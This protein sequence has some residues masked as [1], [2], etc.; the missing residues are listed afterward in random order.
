MESKYFT[1][2]PSQAY[3]KLAEYIDLAIKEGWPSISHRGEKFGKLFAELSSNLKQFLQIPES[4]SV[5]Y[6]GSATDFMERSIQN[7]SAEKTLHFSNGV[8][9]HRFFEFARELGRDAKEVVLRPDFSFNLSDSPEDFDPELVCLT[10]NETSS[11]IILPRQ[12]IS[13]LK[14]KY[15]KAL[16]VLDIVS[17]APVSDVDFSELDVTFFSVQ[18]GFGLPAGLGVA[19]VSPKA[20]K[21]SQA[22][23]LL[24][25]YTGFRSSFKE[26][27]NYYVKNQA[28][29]TPNVFNM[30]L[31][32]EV[33][34]DMMNV[35]LEKIKNQTAE[36]A[37]YL[38]N[39]LRNH[40][41]LEIVVEHKDYKSITTIV[42]KAKHGSAPVIAALETKG[43]VLSAGYGDEKDKY[44]RI[45]NFPSHSMEMI[46]ELAEGLKEIQHD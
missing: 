27:Q 26:L 21:K 46:E 31:L 3:P 11:G 28:P 24:G 40:Q 1:V 37:E 34:K 14:N 32:N 38:F 45:A 17:S 39:A 29:G 22:V 19:F 8:F 33:V 35:G 2:G 23:S 41:E 16:F 43:L 4:Y 12:F 25:K 20:L 7:C 9:S 5:F 13:S 10:H 30:F 6:S 18:K 42:L 36:K 44:I 15:P